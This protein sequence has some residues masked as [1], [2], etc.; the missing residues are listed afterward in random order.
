MTKKKQP[1]KQHSEEFK[2]EA[3]RLAEKIGVTQAANQL[4][5]HGSQIYQWRAALERKATT[6]ERESSL[7][8]E[9][10]RLKRMLAE[11]DQE[12]DILKKAAAYFAKNQK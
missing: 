8:T 7:A 11:R 6:S 3:L 5:L 2:A 10:A 1:R 9:N 12:V 4:S